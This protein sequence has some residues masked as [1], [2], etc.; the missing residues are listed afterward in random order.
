[1]GCGEGVGPA[2]IGTGRWGDFFRSA[3]GGVLVE[4]IV[5]VGARRGTVPLSL[6][7]EGHQAFVL[8]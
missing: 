5:R 4:G 8:C 1:V 2:Y 3:A 6:G 7:V